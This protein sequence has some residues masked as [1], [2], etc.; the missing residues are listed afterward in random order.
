M[1][2]FRVVVLKADFNY[3]GNILSEGAILDIVKNWKKMPL[4]LGETTVEI[5]SL[6]NIEYNKETKEVSVIVTLKADLNLL[7]NNK[8]AIE[9]L[10]GKRVLETEIKKAIFLI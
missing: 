8:Q 1:I 4:I 5:G 7:F 3:S 10:D 2:S 9:T 6:D